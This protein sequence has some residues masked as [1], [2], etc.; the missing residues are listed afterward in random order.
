MA[1]HSKVW[2]W[3][4]NGIV[5]VCLIV[6]LLAWYG[7]KLMMGTRLKINDRESVNYSGK[8]NEAE[9][10]SLGEK[11][12]EIGFFGGDTEKDVLLNKTD[13]ATTVSFIIESGKWNDAEIV[14][15]IE[16]VGRQIA[17]SIGGP[18]IT[19]KLMDDH[20]NTKKVLEISKSETILKVSE[21]ESII[22]SGTITSEEARKA[23]D[24]LKEIGYFDGQGSGTVL[25]D[26]DGETLVLSFVVREDTWKNP[27]VVTGL[28][29][30]GAAV[31]GK[32]PGKK[33][34]VRLVDASLKLQL[35]IP[36]DAESAQPAA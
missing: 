30:V 23:A 19:I 15:D 34:S 13:R 20:L 35:T 8:A 12:Q 22:Y 16:R 1:D 2:Q 4:K 7:Q 18:P 3:V 31:G 6:G 27:E 32:F 28:K 26:Q 11:L 14:A 21:L 25:L 24:A 5:V 33:I 9:A 36:E 10:R 29:Q 17:T